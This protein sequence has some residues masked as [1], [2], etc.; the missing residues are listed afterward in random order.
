MVKSVTEWLRK[1]S[2]GPYLLS[3]KQAIVGLKDAFSISEYE[4]NKGI[5][6]IPS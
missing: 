1:H 2:E 5:L 3:Y 6:W 4:I